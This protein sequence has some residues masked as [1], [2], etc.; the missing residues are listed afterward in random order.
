[1]KLPNFQLIS[2]H[3]CAK[4]DFASLNRLYRDELFQNFFG[5]MHVESVNYSDS[6]FNHTFV[7]K[8]GGQF[9]GYLSISHRI[10]REDV[11]ATTIYYGISP[12][13]RHQ[14]LGSK[15]VKEVSD[16]LLSRGDINTVIMNIDAENIYSQKVAK[17]A[18]FIYMPEFSDDEELQFQRTSRKI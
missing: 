3:Q 5:K 10:V 13:Y 2:L 4:S 17:N 6:I 1:M 15:L 8:D 14:G 16:Y 12:E 7:V 9:L 18:D 11:M